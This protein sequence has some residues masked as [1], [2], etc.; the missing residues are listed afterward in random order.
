MSYKAICGFWVRHDIENWKFKCN[1]E[2][3]FKYWEWELQKYILDK[4]WFYCPSQI[5]SEM[6]KEFYHITLARK[7]EVVNNT[8]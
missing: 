4:Y 2:T 6:R 8:K 3:T 5:K 7:G 1:C